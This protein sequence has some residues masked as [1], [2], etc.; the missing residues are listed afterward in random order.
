M[1]KILL[2]FP[3]TC[4]LNCIYCFIPSNLRQRN[5]GPLNIKQK[6]NEIIRGSKKGRPEKLIIAGGEA[7]MFSKLPNIL[8]F[9]KSL[10]IKRIELQTNATPFYNK[11]LAF[12]LKESGLDSAMVGFHSHIEETYDH[13]T[14]TRGMFKYALYGIE[15]LLAAKIN[16]YINCTICTLNYVN[17]S[18]YVNFLHAK[19]SSINHLMFTFIYPAGRA[20]KNIELLLPRVTDTMHEFWKMVSFCKK[21]GIKI[22]L[23]HCGIPGLPLCVLYKTKTTLSRFPVHFNIDKS[24]KNI[25]T[26]EFDCNNE[27]FKSCSLCK[28]NSF[29]VGIPVRYVKIY[30]QREFKPV[31]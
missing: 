9:A 19:F 26:D 29:C 2:R 24:S 18:E 31:R 28:Y 22:S 16:T 21:N 4:N 5:K 20:L 6:I 17:L 15:N 27:K 14:N 3:L 1:K 13:L 8:S 12:K 11:A 30:G 25:K 7:A 10:G 23:A